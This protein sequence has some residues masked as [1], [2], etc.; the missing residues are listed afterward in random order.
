MNNCTWTPFVYRKI[1]SVWVTFWPIFW[2]YA[3]INNSEHLSLLALFLTFAQ[4]LK[5]WKAKNI[6]TLINVSASYR[7][8]RLYNWF[9]ILSTFYLDFTFSCILLTPH[10]LFHFIVRWDNELL[11]KQHKFT[12]LTYFGMSGI[13][14][15][16]TFSLRLA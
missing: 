7:N 10:D 16:N 1:N 4:R 5:L 13:C 3:E 2:N 11:K 12:Y 14:L 6:W 15:K 8:Q 9:L